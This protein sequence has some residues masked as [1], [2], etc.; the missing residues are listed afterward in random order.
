MT[1]FVLRER[2]AILTPSMPCDEVTRLRQ[3]MADL[4]EKLAEQKRK[5]RNF[6]G[7]SRP[8]RFTAGHSDYEPLLQ[9]RMQEVAQQIESHIAQHRCQE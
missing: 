6:A 4:K 5:A 8:G 9:R 2:S 7:D 3:R 1:V